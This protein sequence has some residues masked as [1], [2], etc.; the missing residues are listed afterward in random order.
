MRVLVTLD[1]AKRLESILRRYALARR[2]VAA[3]ARDC[4]MSSTQR[5][6][7]F[8]M[9]RLGVGG[10]PESLQVMAAFASI[11]EFRRGEL[12]G[13]RVLVTIGAHLEFDV[14][15]RGRRRRYVTFRAFHRSVFSLQRI[16]APGMLA[17]VESRLLELDLGVTARAI[18]FCELPA[19][20]IGLMARIAAVVRHRFL[21]VVGLMALEAVDFGVFPQ[22]R[23][24]R[25]AMIE[26]R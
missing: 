12:R 9:L 26:A 4:R 18:L 10:R 25:P 3:L 2:L 20:G 1:A 19:V 21:E 13:V 15:V 5:E 14:I 8:P 22:Q 16:T 7:R 6:A 17:R 23:I 11:L 24:F